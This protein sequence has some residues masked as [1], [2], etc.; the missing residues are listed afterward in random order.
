MASLKSFTLNP[1]GRLLEL[2]FEKKVQVLR[3]D[4]LDSLI[5]QLGQ[6]RSRME[7]AIPTS[8]TNV[9][10]AHPVEHFYFRRMGQGTNAVPIASGGLFLFQSPR[11]GW[12]QFPASAELC[13]GMAKWLV[14]G[15]P[16]G[17]GA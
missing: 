4:E 11:F 1:D 8:Q 12:F 16:E 6:L 14:T 13:A 15:N 3:A 10:S 9:G 7:P 2:T 5:A 17:A